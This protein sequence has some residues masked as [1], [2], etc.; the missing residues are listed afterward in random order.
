MQKSFKQLHIE[1][2]QTHQT[3]WNDGIDRTTKNHLK[4][5]LF[6]LDQLFQCRFIED[7][8]EKILIEKSI[9]TF[10]T[11][12]YQRFIEILIEKPMTIVIQEEKNQ[13]EIFLEEHDENDENQIEEFDRKIKNLKEFFE[14]LNQYV[15]SRTI[16][17]QPTSNQK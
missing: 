14:I 16:Q 3:L 1:I 10:A 5:Q 6:Y 7:R 11:F 17:I 12:C 2:N 4:L 8:G 9:Q 13:I 15:L